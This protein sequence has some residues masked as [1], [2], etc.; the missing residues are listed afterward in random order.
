MEKIEASFLSGHPCVVDV[1]PLRA[2]IAEFDDWI[3]AFRLESMSSNADPL[4]TLGL[5][6][7]AARY[8][9]AATH[10]MAAAEIAARLNP[11]LYSKDNAL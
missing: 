6:G 8:Q 2:A 1:A 10:L 9:N 3:L 7:R 11:S 4:T 5:L